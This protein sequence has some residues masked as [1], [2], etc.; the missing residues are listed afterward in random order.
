MKRL[1]SVPLIIFLLTLTCFA[2]NECKRNVEPTGGFSFCM[3]DGWMVTEKEG[4][5]FK[6]V[7]GPTGDSFRPNINIKDDVNTS[8]LTDYTAASVKYVLAHY[9]EIGATGMKVIAQDDFI[10]T[11]GMHGIKV[12]YRTDYKG[13]VI[14]TIQYF[15]DGKAGQKLI[16]TC[17]LL[18]A[19]SSTL[20]PI[21]ERTLKTFQLDK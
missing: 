19:D 17:T 9:Q 18:D 16:V 5:K 10:T 21:F 20:D 11:T 15:F 1:L 13:I 6:F 2:Q 14:R 4:E 7:Y 8:L 12:T 3:P